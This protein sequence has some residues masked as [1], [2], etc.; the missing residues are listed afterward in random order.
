MQKI[1]INTHTGPSFSIKNRMLRVLWSIIYITLFKFS[2]KPLH[3]W[4]A[5]LLRMFGAKIGK[6]AHIYPGVKIWAPWNIIIGE[7]TGIASGVNLYS[8]GK[9]KIGNN[10]V[11]S[12]GAHL[13]TG[14]HDYRIKG[15]PL[16]TKP[17][18]IGDNVWIAADV[19]IHPGI[20][21]G[22]GSIIGARSVVDR[23][24]DSWKVC[25]GHPCKQI[26]TRV[27]N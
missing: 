14:T 7:K 26:K 18:E 27:L 3:F 16:F 1:N 2:P 15:F 23:N 20:N 5:L 25:S 17:I 9:I 21:I 13:C 6:G 8:Q 10:T 24:I 19:F 22:E 11:I 12:Q 4:R